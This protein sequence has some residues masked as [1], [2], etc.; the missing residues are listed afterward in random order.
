MKPLKITCIA[1]LILVNAETFAAAKVDTAALI[2]QIATHRAPDTARVN[3]LN[4]AGFLLYR[5]KA[6]QSHAYYDEA[7]LL[8]QKL[9]YDNG[10]A[11][12]ALGE[13]FFYRFRGQFQQAL[14][15]TKQAV[16]LYA[17]L[18][19]TLNLIA[20]DYNLIN[21]YRLQNDLVNS[22]ALNL[23]ALPLAESV[24]SDKWMIL[25]NNLLSETYDRI[26]DL[27]KATVYVNR[28][29]QIAKKANDLDGLEHCYNGLSNIASNRGQWDKVKYYMGLCTAINLKIN[30]HQGYLQSSINIG[31]ADVY[32]KQYDT[33]LRIAYKA[34]AGI[35]QSQNYGDIPYAQTVL[36]RAYLGK[37]QADSAIKYGLLS[38]QARRSSGERFSISSASLVLA[39]AYALS[40]Q[41]QQA[42]QYQVQYANYRDSI[43]QSQSLHRLDAIQYTNDLDK[44]QSQITLLKRN[45]DLVSHEAR[46]QKILLI[47][48]IAVI[49][50][51]IVFSVVLFRSNQQKQLAV[52]Q[53]L[54]RQEELKATQNQLIQSEKMAS[55]GELT[56]GIAHEIQ[57]P[58]NFVNN[59]SEV[60]REMIE[61]LRTELRSGNLEEALA[62]VA[63]IEQNEE[64]ITHHGKR[65]DG[66]VKGMLQHSRTTAGEKQPTNINVLADEFLKLS[67]HGLRAKDKSF[68]AELVTN[69]DENL[70]RINVVQQDIG[71]V[72]LNLFNN[73]FYAVNERK[74]LEAGS[75]KPEVTVTT[76]VEN[77]QLLIAVKDNGNGI[78]DAIKDKI[79][80]PFFT[81]KPTGEGTGLGLSLSYDI[82]MKGHGGSI[83]V[84]SVEGEGTLFVVELPIN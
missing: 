7:Y 47:F 16:T 51:A 60:N 15:Y 61:E 45:A 23:K 1:V 24:H 18:G 28:A 6:N 4:K 21:T 37:G 59:F 73:A 62:I 11:G 77:N 71:R 25:L 75:W 69:F 35:G 63:D 9:H 30:N 76:S 67:Y 49:I 31:E 36:A 64:K 82:V 65:A 83:K 52:K 14:V 10:L 2:K 33:A 50:A 68:N 20:S 56:A 44:K 54:R 80:Q 22:V 48:S 26:D 19:D 57:N 66:I 74:K 42:Y 38:V 27:D 40:G 78:P 32:L 3:L 13:G 58:L 70:P 72:L 5:N 39:Q 84:E 8:A 79:M 55:L 81:T 46:Q 41:Y 17:K 29:L 43:N 12:A 53:L 34:L